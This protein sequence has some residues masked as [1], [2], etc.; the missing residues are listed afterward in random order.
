VAN[1]ACCSEGQGKISDEIGPSEDF[2]RRFRIVHS[3]DPAGEAAMAQKRGREGRATNGHDLNIGHRAEEK[4]DLGCYLTVAAD[5]G[6][7]WHNPR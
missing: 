5:Q 3:A 7:G 1:F 6:Y 4:G 2:S